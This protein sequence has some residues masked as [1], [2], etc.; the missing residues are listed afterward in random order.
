MSTCFSWLLIILGGRNWIDN[1]VIDSKIISLFKACI[2]CICNKIFLLYNYCT[3]C[4]T[5]CLIFIST[6]LD[7]S[8]EFDSSLYSVCSCLWKINSLCIPN[9][10]LFTLFGIVCHINWFGKLYLFACL[11]CNICSFYI[12]NSDFGYLCTG[13]YVI[14]HLKACCCCSIRIKHCLVVYSRTSIP[15][16]C[17]FWIILTAVAWCPAWALFLPNL[18]I[19][20]ISCRC[21]F[22]W[23]TCGISNCNPCRLPVIYTKSTCFIYSIDEISHE[24]SL[25]LHSERLCGI[26]RVI[27]I[28]LTNSISMTIW[29]IK[30]ICIACFYNHCILVVLRLNIA[31]FFL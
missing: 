5:G 3:F 28:S 19:C 29:I 1:L 7:F 21:S 25:S 9:N 6:T 10:V 18:F 11:S 31:E 2:I 16:S 17:I 15:F 12:L 24:S 14:P 4:C 22:L 8:A 20:F 26:C 23:K 27:I 30:C 13:L